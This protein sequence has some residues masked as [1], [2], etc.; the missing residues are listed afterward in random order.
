[1]ASIVPFAIALW[2]DGTVGCLEGAVLVVVAASLM[3][4]LYHR[5]PVF[6]AR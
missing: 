2:N 1:M 5:S 4:W 3:I 6:G